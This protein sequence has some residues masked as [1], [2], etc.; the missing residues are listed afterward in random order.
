MKKCLIALLLCLGTLA[1]AQTTREGAGLQPTGRGWG[2]AND[3]G[4]NSITINGNGINY[5]GGPVINSGPTIYY[6]WY[7]NW[8]GNTATSILTD[9]A[10]SIGGTPYFNINTTYYFTND[11]THLT[12]VANHVAYGGST[13]DNYS[14]GKRLSDSKVKLVVANAINHGALPKDA[15]GV[16]FVLTSSDVAESSGFCSRYCGWHTNASIAGADIKYSFVGNPDRCPNACEAQSSASPNNNTGA[17]GMASVIAHELEESTTDPDLNAWYDS[18]GNENADKCAWTFGT[19]S[20]A[21]N[22]SKYNVTWG[23]RQ[24][25]IQRNWA[26]ASGGYCSMSF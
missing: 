26:N 14:Q 21:S 2:E 17:D 7:G 22:G 16:Y 3:S 5:H 10:N 9:M 23:S 4:V 1:Y 24:Y 19:T 25:L 12:K 8:Q 11:G 18:S 20:T 15:N 6:I 13:S